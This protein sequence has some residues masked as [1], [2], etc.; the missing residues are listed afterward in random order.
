MKISSQLPVLSYKPKR[1]SW[2]PSLRCCLHL[3][4]LLE[5]LFDSADH[6][7]GLFRNFVVLALMDLVEAA[8]RF[9]NLH[10]ASL[11]AGELLGDVERL[12]EE[13]LDLAGTRDG[14]LVV[15]TQFIDTEN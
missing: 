14:Q 6:V 1:Q 3:F 8:N 5:H 4:G 10:V 2:Q 13:L 12:R 9:R 7:E 15:F 11:H